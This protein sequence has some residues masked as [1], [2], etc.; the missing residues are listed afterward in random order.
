[1]AGEND[2]GNGSGDGAAAGGDGGQ[3]GSSTPPAGGGTNGSSGSG[4]GDGSG[5]GEGDGSGSG[6]GS[7]SRADERV[8]EAL[9]A[10]TAAERERDEALQKLKDIEE[11][12][13]SEKEKAERRAKEAEER[14]TAAESR[15][16]TLERNGWIRDAASEFAN[17]QDAIEILAGKLGDLDSEAK[18]KKAVKELGENRPHL[19]RGQQSSPFPGF[20]APSGGAPPPPP[21]GGG[22]EGAPQEMTPEQAKAG[23]AADIGAML[24]RRGG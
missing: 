23:I 16:T 6:S 8:R 7:G 13:L 10:K 14:A 24:S 12:D 3:G 17:P 18:A 11:R 21:A 4:S 20:G 1:M 19:L 15:A 9:G 2:N 5:S 22:G